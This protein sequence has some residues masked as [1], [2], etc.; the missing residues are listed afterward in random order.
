M[1]I[2]ILSFAHT[3]ALSYARLLA[4]RPDV[5]LAACDPDS[6]DVADAGPR[7]TALADELGIA[8][9]ETYEE[10][11]AWSP[12]AVIVTAENARHRDLVER[13]AAAGAHIL[14]EK[15]LAT[16]IADAEA[17]L[18]AVEAAGV[19]LMVAY[20]VRFAATFD[21][22]RERLR[23]GEIGD[24]LGVCGTNNGKI[25]LAD[26]AWFTD[27]ELAGGGAL[28]DHVVHCADL[29]DDLLGEQA[30]SVHAAANRI[31]HAGRGVEV[32][33]GGL[34]TVTYPSGVV[35][36]I[37]CS[38]SVP[39]AASTWGGLTLQLLGTRGT[40][41][42]APFASHLG[43]Y[44]VNGAVYLPVGDDLDALM[45]DAFIRAVREGGHP[46]PDGAVGVRTLRIV[47]AA[48][49]SVRTGTAVA[50]A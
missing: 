15:P 45:L 7:G 28:V 11:F 27:P 23:A 17:M 13:A 8:Y 21:E 47:D 10:V 33:T 6:A 16:T 32:E 34:V 4:A 19:E 35:A 48:Q 30:Q 22:A 24:L 41:T 12:D 38:W 44:D 36:T 2:A 39:D 25:P 3:H 18:S 20:P 5:E 49:R 9:M 37:D 43:G 29:L 26:R 1:R 14:C 42:I 50:I 46:Q 40:I 31:L